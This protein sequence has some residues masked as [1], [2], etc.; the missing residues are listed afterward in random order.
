MHRL[1]SLSAFLLLVV[2]ALL[3][4]Q[5]APIALKPESTVLALAWSADG[6][7]LAVGSADGMIR[8]VA[9]PGGKEVHRV[10]TGA[11][12]SGVV[13]TQ[14]GKWLGVKEGTPSG[15]LCIWD[16]QKGQKLKQLAYNGYTCNQLAF[17]ADG[18][19][20]VA[21]GPGEHMVWQHGK[22]SGYGS[23]SSQAAGTSAAA[24]PN[25]TIVAWSTPQ[26][27]AQ[28]HHLEPRRYQVLDLG[29][30]SAFAFSA[31]AR[32]LAVAATDKSIRLRPLD[33]AEV[34]KFEGLREPAK[35]LQ[36]SANGKVLVGA[37]PGDPVVRLWDVAS[38]RLRRR[39]TTPAAVKVLALSGDGH[40]L[41]L[42]AD[43]QVSLWNVATREVGDLGEPRQLSATEMKHAWE[44]LAS[45]DADKAETAF[46]Q[47][48]LAQQHALDFL[49]RHV[50]AIAVPPLDREH[51]QRL[52]IE[53][54]A[55]T[56][57]VRQRAFLELAQQGELAVPALEQYL[58]RKPSVEGKRRATKLLAGQ[59]Q[60]ETTPDRLRC[61]EAIELLEILKTA[62]ARTVVEDLA[63]EALITQL[64]MA[65]RE[66]LERW[67]VPQGK[68]ETAPSLP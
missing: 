29:P 38:G 3:L 43:A 42:A 49:Y 23:R 6:K 53:L 48:A 8:I 14:D 18:Q 55:P 45:S 17:S 44:D 4:G 57:Q 39:I 24:A 16:I 66:A 34:R 21:A 54:D 13:F 62:Q 31:D 27:R 28:L 52:L 64:R 65:A 7:H 32:W 41:A 46:R 40:T 35:L 30:L 15:P 10:N 26:G 33:G 25:G 59:R 12:V 63:R 11:P 47:F 60:P 51:Q 56:Y 58:T 19:T 36:F 37:A 1:A 61:L 9:L 50:R 67:P 68:S 2:P 22:G 5:G 20:L